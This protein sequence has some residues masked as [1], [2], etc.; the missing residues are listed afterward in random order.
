MPFFLARATSRL[1]WLLWI[2]YVFLWTTLLVVPFPDLGQWPLFD[3]PIGDKYLIGKAGHVCAY[4]LMTILTGW[5]RVGF[6]ARLLLL[7]FLMAHASATEWVQL[8]LSNRTGLVDDIV[9]DHLGILT[10]L[11]LSWKWWTRAEY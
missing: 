3:P 7:F 11:V 5:L 2:C 1:R 6:Q 10:G 4:A 8:H 9:L